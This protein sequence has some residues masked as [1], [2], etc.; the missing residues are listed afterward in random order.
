MIKREL[1]KKI[2]LENIRNAHYIP[3]RIIKGKGIEIYENPINLN[4]IR[5]SIF[6][7]SAKN[8]K[9]M[10]IN[11]F[12]KK[13]K[14]YGGISN[15]IIYSIVYEDRNKT[16]KNGKYFHEY[17]EYGT[18]KK[19][20]QFEIYND[21]L[22]KIIDT[23]LEGIESLILVLK[24]K[25]LGYIRISDYTTNLDSMQKLIYDL[26]ILSKRKIYGYFDDYD[27]AECF[28]RSYHNRD[29]FVCGDYEQIHGKSYYTFDSRDCEYF[30]GRLKYINNYRLNNFWIPGELIEDN[31]FDEIDPDNKYTIFHRK[32]KDFYISPS[33]EENN[34]EIAFWNG[35]IKEYNQ[36]F[37]NCWDTE[38][39]SYL[40]Y[41]EDKKIEE[42][43]FN[44]LKSKKEQL[45]NECYIYNELKLGN[46][47]EECFDYNDGVF[48]TFFL[49]IIFKGDIWEAKNYI[50]ENLNWNK[51]IKEACQDINHELLNR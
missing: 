2:I 12:L 47:V 8:K 19:E 18:N 40:S 43:L 3:Y 9:E 6:L 48:N 44:V 32:G 7:D 41:E 31:W 20:Y 13:V 11:K 17:I 38:E 30:N 50:F 39:F 28:N 36:G 4:K 25:K 23:K 49:D 27:N 35:T 10:L 5:Y 24:P 37:N 21:L 51:N 14:K 33:L 34:V 45:E 46:P 15:F 1:I 42:K 22:K 16:L 26:S 29:V